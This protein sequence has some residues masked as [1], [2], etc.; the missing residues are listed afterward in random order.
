[1]LA[2]LPEQSDDVVVIEAIEDHPT[3]TASA[4]EP[5]TAEQSQLMRHGRLADPQQCGEVANAELSGR[6]RR[7]NSDA[8]GVAKH[9]ED[10]GKAIDG[11]GIGHLRLDLRDALRFGVKDLATVQCAGGFGARSG[12]HEYLSKCSDIHR[13]TIG[14]RWADHFRQ[15]HGGPPKL[16]A[17]AEAPAH[18]GLSKA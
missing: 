6:E 5:Q 2:A 16:C 13:S 7:Q 14:A 3:V 12:L 17:T 18:S 11:R 9:L 1:V 4:N 15:G 10:L 8:S